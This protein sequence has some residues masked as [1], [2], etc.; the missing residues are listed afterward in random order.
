MKRV[1]K[2]NPKATREIQ[3]LVTRAHAECGTL[4]GLAV[5]LG[6]PLRTLEDW[7]AG[8][9]MPHKYI[10]ENVVKNLRAIINCTYNK[11]D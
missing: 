11:K 2:E 4:R 8:K 7:K 9:S 3:D 6:T 10:R 1:R 5:V